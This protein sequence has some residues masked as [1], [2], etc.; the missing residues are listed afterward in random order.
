MPRLGRRPRPRYPRKIALRVGR[1][2]R[3]RVSR[4]RSTVAPKAPS[5]LSAA[6]EPVFLPGQAVSLAEV[7]VARAA[8]LDKREVYKTW[9]D[10]CGIASAPSVTCDKRNWTKSVPTQRV[11]SSLA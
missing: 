7:Q 2:Q 11:L 10:V 4:G 8:I 9:D 1:R 3:G 5:Q 6:V